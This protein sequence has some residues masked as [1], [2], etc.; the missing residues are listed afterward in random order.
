MDPQGSFGGSQPNA[1]VSRLLKLALGLFVTTSDLPQLSPEQQ[2]NLNFGY[3]C[4]FDS[5]CR[6]SS[7]GNSLNHWMQAKGE[8]EKILWLAA[9]GAVQTPKEPFALIELKGGGE[10]ADSLTSDV[11][12]CQDNN[13]LF[14]FTYWTVGSADLEICLLDQY[15][16]KFNCTGFLHSPIQ[17]GKVSLQ[18]P[19]NLNPFYISLIPNVE[20]GIIVLDDI[21]YETTFCSLTTM[22]PRSK[23]PQPDLI[24]PWTLPPETPPPPPFTLLPPL[25]P[26]TFL[27]LP[28]DTPQS[29]TAMTFEPVT[30]TRETTTE[31]AQPA[32]SLTPTIRTINPINP[33]EPP[34]E[35]LVIGKHTRP[36]FDQRKN[37][38]VDDTAKLLCDFGGD[39]QC[40]WGAEAGKWAIIDKE[41]IPSL[42]TM[43]SQLPSFPAALII[44]G[45]A[46]LTSDPL[47]CQTGSGSL[48][49]RYWSNGD[50][51]LQGC[52]LAYGQES[53]QFQCAEEHGKNN[54]ALNSTLAVFEFPSSITEPFTLNIVPTWDENARN[55]Y[56]IIDEI[57]YIGNCTLAPE[58]STTIASTMTTTERT[59]VF[60]AKPRVIRPIMPYVEV[61]NTRRPWTVETLPP[62]PP[63]TRRIQATTPAEVPYNYCEVLNC[64]FNS[65]ACNYLNHGLTKVPWT[66]RNRGYGYPLSRITDVKPTIENGQFVSTILNP[67]DYAIL[68]SPTFKPTENINVLLFQYYRP[69]HATTIRLC[70]GT[71]FTKPLRTIQ[72]FTQCPPIL[73]TITSRNA[74]KW[75]SVHI[76]LPPGTTYFYLVA[77][78]TDKAYEKTAIAIDNIRIANC[79]SST[80]DSRP[81]DY[82]TE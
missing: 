13:A 41:A 2:N 62:H 28:T 33:T 61:T 3:D 45:T 55:Q 54:I 43:A 39:F 72:S 82:T 44:Q 70:L 38:I 81:E 64:D 67:G 30:A 36:L 9:T 16:Q 14:S 52:A 49:F 42:E 23:Q 47:R 73:R 17:P 25:V 1:F 26:S 21:R 68:E 80:P 5:P 12:M 32:T 24:L 77:H 10:P 71:S 75:N 65:N 37:E 79:D 58:I 6:W 48:L 4:A 19:A 27:P 78:N 53:S 50:V 46:M 22:R 51:L 29:V 7:T 31:T 57:A 20:S 66:L 69:T 56:L 18:I 34:F 63:P 35:L 74:F 11:I 8:P 15:K 60:T 59:T 76:Q 40:Q